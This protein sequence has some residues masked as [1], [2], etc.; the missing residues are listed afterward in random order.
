MDILP[1]AYE[2]IY[3]TCRSAITT[4][5]IGDSLYD[6]LRIELEKAVGQ[7]ETE[8]A[9]LGKND[10]AWISSLN[11]YFKWFEDQIVKSGAFVRNLV[12]TCAS[13]LFSSL[14]SPTWTKPTS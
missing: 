9:T 3:S 2:R 6:H 4:S 12:L 7:M 14:F 8:M 10:V 5:A 1:V 13:S 11:E